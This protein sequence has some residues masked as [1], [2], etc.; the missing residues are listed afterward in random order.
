MYIYNFV[1]KKFKK[2]Q[3]LRFHTGFV[4][5]IVI[6]NKNIQ[7]SIFQSTDLIFY[8]I[9]ITLGRVNINHT[10]IMLQKIITKFNTIIIIITSK[11]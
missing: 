8:Y 5:F 4:Y 3:I 9:P 1:Y 6:Y 2:I 10:N 7:E 11:M